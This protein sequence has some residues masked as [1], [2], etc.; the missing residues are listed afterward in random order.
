M[1]FTKF[2]PM[3]GISISFDSK[4]RRLTSLGIWCHSGDHRKIGDDELY[5]SMSIPLS[6]HLLNVYASLQM[7]A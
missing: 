7:A 4:H 5:V 6:G 3:T 2:V 1:F